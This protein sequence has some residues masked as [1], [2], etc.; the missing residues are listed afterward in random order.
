LI[1]L[2]TGTYNA[3]LEKRNGRWVITR[4]YIEA[5]AELAPSKFPGGKEV[6][7]IP[8]P[9]FVI[10]DAKPGPLQGKVTLKEHPYSM[11][12]RGPLYR[13]SP[14]PLYWKDSDF[15]IVDFLTDVRAAAEFLPEGVTTFPIPDLP[16]YSAVKHIWA[17][18]RQSSVGPYDELIV[19]IP[20]V[21]KNQM[22]LYVPLI[23]VTTDVAMSSGREIGGWPKKIADIR[24]ERAGNTYRLSF[25][26]HRMEL[27]ASATV[28]YKLFSTPLPADEPVPLAFP[29]NMTLPLPPPTGKPQPSV[30]LPTLTLKIIPGVGSEN[31]GPEVAQLIGAPWRL[32]G[33]FYGAG[34]ITVSMYPTDEDPIAK[35]PVLKVLGGTYVHGDMTL[36]IKEMRVL[37]DFL[38]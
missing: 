33:D 2:T 35:L 11:P 23:Y 12:A 27:S 38:K 20:S 24:M 1:V 31:P 25:S 17:H 16:G 36:A 30:P 8:D 29:H 6:T 28:G 10:P 37:H 5:D 32:S 3:E 15:V 26:R 19:A 21:Y 18:Y 7:Y 34:G 14:Q 9:Q 22:W 4:W 13:L